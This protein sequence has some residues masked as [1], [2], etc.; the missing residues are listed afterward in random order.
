MNIRHQD[1]E[2]KLLKNPKLLRHGAAVRQSA[3]GKIIKEMPVSVASGELCI[4]EY[5]IC[6][7][8]ITV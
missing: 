1:Q 3:S 2:T 5:C 4:I 8:Q 6:W 7:C